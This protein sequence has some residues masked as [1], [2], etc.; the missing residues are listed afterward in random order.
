MIR[1][2]QKESLDWMKD[3]QAKMLI[4]GGREDK[5]IKA[6][7]LRKINSFLPQIKIEIVQNA[8]H[9]LPYE[10]PMTFNRLIEAFIEAK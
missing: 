9:I 5:R 2:S 10:V 8:G 7:N 1:V 6:R 4:I 3:Y